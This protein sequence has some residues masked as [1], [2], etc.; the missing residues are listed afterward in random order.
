M[1]ATAE[2]FMKDV[3]NQE[4]AQGTKTMKTMKKKQKS[5]TKKDGTAGSPFLAWFEEQ[6]GKPRLNEDDYLKLMHE[7]VPQLRAELARA[8]CELA[9]ANR[10]RTA[11]QYA[12]YAWCAKEATASK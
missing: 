12:L 1:T 2:N 6:A 7:T 3:S 5:L 8:E 11:K 10:Y 9:E 4:H